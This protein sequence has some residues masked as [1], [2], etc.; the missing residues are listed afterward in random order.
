LTCVY[1]ARDEDAIRVNEMT[2]E[3]VRESTKLRYQ[4]IKQI[5]HLRE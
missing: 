2:C 4:A 3:A 5:R 1:G